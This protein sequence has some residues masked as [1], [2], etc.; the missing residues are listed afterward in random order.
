ME[1]S[2]LSEDGDIDGERWRLAFDRTDVLL[3][4]VNL[5]SVDC[6]KRLD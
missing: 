2:L 6:E 5:S 4:L 3:L 1:E